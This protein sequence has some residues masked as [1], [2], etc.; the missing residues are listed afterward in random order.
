MSIENSNPVIYDKLKEREVL[1]QDEDD[2]VFDD[3]DD[4]EI[5]GKSLMSRGLLT[6][7]TFPKT[8]PF[9]YCSLPK[10]DSTCIQ[11]PHFCSFRG[12]ILIKM[13]IDSC[14]GFEVFHCL[15]PIR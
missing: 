5:F 12:Y 7:Q 15:L 2:S 13:C 10:L 4:R 3:I 8:V 14:T 11:Q 1:P 6:V 9:G